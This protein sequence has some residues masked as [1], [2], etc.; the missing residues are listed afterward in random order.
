MLGAV[1]PVE[2][3]GLGRVVRKLVNANPGLKTN[4]SMYISCIETFFTAYVLRLFKFK[5]EGQKI[6]TENLTAKLQN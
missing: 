3:V 1:A 2:R 5:T 6:L 4:C